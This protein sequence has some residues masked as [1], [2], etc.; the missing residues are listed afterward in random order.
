MGGGGDGVVVSQFC[1]IFFSCFLFFV[2]VVFVVSFVA[3]CCAVLICGV[4]RR[5][6]T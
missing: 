6:V 2:F 1:P 4:G 5:D 3:V